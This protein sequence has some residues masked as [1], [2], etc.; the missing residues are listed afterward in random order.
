MS[1]LLKKI[2]HHLEGTEA[3]QV[4]AR[5]RKDGKWIDETYEEKTWG[6]ERWIEDVHERQILCA[7]DLTA[8]ILFK[9]SGPGLRSHSAIVKKSEEELVDGWAGELVKSA[10]SGEIKAIHCFTLLPF[11]GDLDGLDWALTINDAD[12]FLA[13]RGLSWKCG[14]TVQHIYNET[15]KDL[16]GTT[17]LANKKNKE[18]TVHT[19]TQKRWTDEKRQELLDYKLA[20]GTNSAA[21][22]FGI[23]GARV[24]QV[25]GPIKDKPIPTSNDPFNSKNK[26]R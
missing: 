14:D 4:K 2:I 1:E 25:I 9:L 7:L 16:K 21:E 19:G 26:H 8:L 22:K 12:L 20:H 10:Q 24:R 11:V 5:V 15:I 3:K 23:S 18:N 6:P 17:N 13:A